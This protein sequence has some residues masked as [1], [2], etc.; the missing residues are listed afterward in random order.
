MR[1]VNRDGM[2]TYGT[3]TET[4]INHASSSS[5]PDGHLT[6]AEASERTGLSQRA[7][8]RALIEGRLAGMQVMGRWAVAVEGLDDYSRIARRHRPNGATAPAAQHGSPQE[9]VALVEE[10]RAVVDRAITAEARAVEAETRLRLIESGSSAVEIERDQLR[11]QIIDLEAQLSA[12]RSSW[13]PWRR[14][15]GSAAA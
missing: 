4:I 9:L 14:D 8:R 1:V 11:A 3:D 6:V 5:V 7:I 2:D 13:W 12:R 15:R 10:L